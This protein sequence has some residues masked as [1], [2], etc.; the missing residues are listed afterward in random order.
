MPRCRATSGPFALLPLLL[1]L[2][3]CEPAHNEDAGESTEARPIGEVS[4]GSGRAAGQ[5]TQNPSRKAFFGDLHVH[6]AWS[7]DSYINFNNTGPR[8]AYRFALGEQ[9][10]LSG[11]RTLQLKYPLDFV[12]VTEHAEYLGELRVCLDRDDPAYDRPVCSDMRN[13]TRDLSRITEVFREVIIRDSFSPE[14]ARNTALCGGDLSNCLPEA[15]AVWRELGEIAD[16]YYSPGQLTTF[17]GYEWTANTGANN[18]HRNVIFANGQVPEMP[19]SYFEANTPRSLWQQLAAACVGDCDVL[20]IPH[21][22]NQ[23]NG[24]QFA[25]FD[26]GGAPIDADYAAMRQQFEPLVEIIQAKGDSECRTGFG[27][28]DEMCRFEKLDLRP[29]C[30][31]ATTGTRDCAVA[32]DASGRPEGCVWPRNYVRNALKTGL[33]I[34]QSLGVNPFM[35]GVVGSTDTHNGTPGGTDETNY[36]G[37]HGVEDGSPAARAAEPALAAFTPQRLKGSGGLAA[38]WAEENSRE[39]IFAA[40]KRRE[41]FATSGTR[42]RVRFFAGWNLPQSLKSRDDL[43]ETGYR[44]G[45]PMGSSLP[46]ATADSAPG[47]LAWAM[48]GVDG[49]KLQRL[50]IVKGWLKDGIAEERV[51]DI[52]CSDSLLPDAE[53]GRCPD[54]GATVNLSDC[55]VS[56]GH[57]ATQLRAVWHDP[58]FDPAARA[59]YYVR[60]LE[61]PG[62]R[63]STYEAIREGSELFTDVDPAIQE[64]AWT[65]PIWYSPQQAI[66]GN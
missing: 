33:Q 38:V 51:Y 11:G 31:Q 59:F 43:V 37:H 48:Q 52:A 15:R 29:A 17:L 63:W 64:R 40:L 6:T 16:E 3:S 61:N 32:C 23:S 25:Q 49:N 13:E 9:V 35:F 57:G 47:F 18:L 4:A 20:L 28:N 27:T 39:S 14:P 5:A 55:S 12:A 19:V 46:P 22:S 1:V 42:I 56:G 7:L 21:N 66:A 44:Q 8:D 58:D 60:V 34:E 62:C 30:A 2:L 41:T 24:M 53:S 50:Q 54:N 65:S 36:Q 26:A 10:S 45:V